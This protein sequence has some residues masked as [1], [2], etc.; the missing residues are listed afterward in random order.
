[1]TENGECLHDLNVFAKAFKALREGAA[2]RA[3]LRGGPLTD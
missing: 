1:M 3:R 2:T